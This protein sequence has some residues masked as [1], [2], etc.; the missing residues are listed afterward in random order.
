[1]I[2]ESALGALLRYYVTHVQYLTFDTVLL[3]FH[4]IYSTGVYISAY[5][6]LNSI[7]IKLFQVY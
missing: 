6:L 3:E 1:M 5:N 4:N 7:I 2:H